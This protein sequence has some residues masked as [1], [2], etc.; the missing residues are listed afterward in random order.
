ME[1]LD[2]LDC[3]FLES[4]YQKRIEDPEYL[5]GKSIFFLMDKEVDYDNKTVKLFANAT[6][7]CKLIRGDTKERLR[8][9]SAHKF[10]NLDFFEH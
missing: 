5:S 10:N 8:K 7:T 3:I 4:L 1:V 6:E 9:Q 2:D